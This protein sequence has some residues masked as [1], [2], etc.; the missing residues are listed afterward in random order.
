M[1]GSMQSWVQILSFLAHPRKVLNTTN[2]DSGGLSFQLIN[3][4]EKKKNSQTIAAT[5]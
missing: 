2:Y 3:S 1:Y 4:G 5:L